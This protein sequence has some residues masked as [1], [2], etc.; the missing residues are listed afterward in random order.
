MRRELHCRLSLSFREIAERGPDISP[1]DPR[2]FV[3]PGGQ[4][5]TCMAEMKGEFKNKVVRDAVDERMWN[6]YTEPKVCIKV[7]KAKSS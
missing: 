2:Q 5:W 6:I 7:L 1:Q 4:A 3:P